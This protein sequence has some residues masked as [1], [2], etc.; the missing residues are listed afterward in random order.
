[1]RLFLVLWASAGGRGRVCSPACAPWLVCKLL[2]S[3]S[4]CVG[5]QNGFTPLHIACK[6]NHIRVMELLLK[7]GAS[8]DAV[9]EVGET[10]QMGSGSALIFLL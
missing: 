1:M 5:L 3:V 6:K 4:L 8:I 7:T 9:T 2:I 10:L